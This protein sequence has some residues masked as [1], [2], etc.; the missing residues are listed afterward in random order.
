MCVCV[1]VSGTGNCVCVCLFACAG[2]PSGSTLIYSRPRTELLSSERSNKLTRVR[3]SVTGNRENEIRAVD[4]LFATQSLPYLSLCKSG[5]AHVSFN[6]ATPASA[7]LPH[8]DLLC[9]EGVWNLTGCEQQN[10]TTVINGTRLQASC[11]RGG[12]PD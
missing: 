6:V 5:L 7:L 3:S 2:D 12:C 4:A 9:H 1:C 8:L 11:D 10:H